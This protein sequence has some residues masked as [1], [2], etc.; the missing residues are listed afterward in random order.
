MNNLITFGTLQKDGTLTNIEIISQSILKGCP[1]TIF[2][3]SHYRED[4][5]CK[6]SN[7]KHRK[8]MIKHWDYT[9]KD[10]KDIPLID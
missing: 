6:C 2:D 7:K 8:M 3:P 4:G 9:K 10:F 1:F 5:S